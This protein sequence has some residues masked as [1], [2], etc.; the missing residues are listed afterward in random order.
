MHQPAVGQASDARHAF[1]VGIEIVE[2]LPFQV[3][4][5]LAVR[6]GLGKP[7]LCV[8][9]AAGADDQ[10]AAV[11]ADAARVVDEG[12]GGRPAGVVEHGIMQRRHNAVESLVCTHAILTPRAVAPS[13]NRM[14]FQSCRAPLNVMK[15]LRRER[16]RDKSCQAGVQSHLMLPGD[17]KVWNPL[18]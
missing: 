12:R 14:A 18:P 4:A 9:L 1:V 2:I 17:P 11:H 13:P 7:D 5:A 8:G 16:L 6:V 3:L 10:R 15:A